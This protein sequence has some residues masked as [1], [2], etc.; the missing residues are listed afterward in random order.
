MTL[1]RESV[2]ET[3]GNSSERSHELTENSPWGAGDCNRF[4][5][6]LHEL[7]SGADEL[8]FRAT[9]VTAKAEL[10]RSQSGTERI[11]IGITGVRPQLLDPQF[12]Y[13]ERCGAV[14]RLL[15]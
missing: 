4:V 7:S 9:T 12:P 1:P 2:S 3:S 8:C 6:C 15:E 5:T 14:V 10:K 13:L 11:Q